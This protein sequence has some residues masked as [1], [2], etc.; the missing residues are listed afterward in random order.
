MSENTD[1]APEDAPDALVDPDV[2]EVRDDEVNDEEVARS[3]P[4][5]GGNEQ[6]PASYLEP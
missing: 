4:D 6:D 2:D 3:F 1:P 5:E